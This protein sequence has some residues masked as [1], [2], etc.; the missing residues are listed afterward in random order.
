MLSG[1]MSRK[2]LVVEDDAIRIGTFRNDLEPHTVHVAISVEEAKERL[3]QSTYDM[4]FLDHDL[5]FGERTYI[6]PEE[7]DTGYQLA[8]WMAGQDRFRTL[9]VVIHSFNWFGANRI[10]RLL[11]NSVYIPFG[12]YPLAEVARLFLGEKLDPRL[13][14]LSNV[15]RKCGIGI[16]PDEA[17]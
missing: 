10:L 17:D 16:D 3:I 13:S 4:V 12:L 6:D 15:L 2:I 14:N 7:A 1:Q 9:P 5:E 8:K 11:D